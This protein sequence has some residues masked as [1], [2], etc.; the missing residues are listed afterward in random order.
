MYSSDFVYI[1]LQNGTIVIKRA[2]EYSKCR[3]RSAR[4]CK[5]VKRVQKISR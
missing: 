1:N 4:T 5:D 2:L 3:K